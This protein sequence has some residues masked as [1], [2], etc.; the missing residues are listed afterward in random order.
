M[1]KVLPDKEDFK[2]W[3]RH[4]EVSF[5]K[6]MGIEIE[7]G[8]VSYSDDLTVQGFKLISRRDALD[9]MKKSLSSCLV[10]HDYSAMFQQVYNNNRKQWQIAVMN[11]YDHFREYIETLPKEKKASKEQELRAFGGIIAIGTSPKAYTKSIPVIITLIDFLDDEK[12]PTRT[13]LSERLNYYNHDVKG[14][15]LGDWLILLEVADFVR[16]NQKG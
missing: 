13:K 6:Y 7:K 5:Y 3:R 9:N 11:Y 1:K 15:T 14:S 16:D 4:L 2:G 12:W 8:A 10:D